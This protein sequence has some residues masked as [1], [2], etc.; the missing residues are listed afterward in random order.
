MNKWSETQDPEGWS[1]MEF[2]QPLFLILFVFALLLSGC[3]T[4]PKTGSQSKEL[5]VVETLSKQTS[6]ES[7]PFSA[8]VVIEDPSQDKENVGWPSIMV[9]NTGTYPIDVSI[10][11]SVMKG[12]TIIDKQNNVI[13]NAG[14][15]S[16]RQ[17]YPGEAVKGTLNYLYQEDVQHDWK[18]KVDLRNGASAKIIAS[19][20]VCLAFSCY[21][22]PSEREPV[23]EKEI[24]AWDTYFEECRQ[25]YPQG[26][27]NNGALAQKFTDECIRDYAVEFV[28]LEECEQIKDYALEDECYFKLAL[29][30]D[31]S[32]VCD[33]LFGDQKIRCIRSVNA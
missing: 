20:T 28:L 3:T 32:G 23:E 1:L 26:Q 21:D 11:V 27:W 5:V 2:R 22:L 4:T 10:D 9:E 25:K 17:I 6:P 8:N 15:N 19:D 24:V 29:A 31:D 7:S 13:F 12:S 30:R 33:L 18:L 16:I 14:D